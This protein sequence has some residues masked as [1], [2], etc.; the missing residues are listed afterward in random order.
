METS[1]EDEQFDLCE[2]PNEP[3]GGCGSTTLQTIVSTVASQLRQH[4]QQPTQL[5][6]PACA[7][8]MSWN[9]TSVRRSGDSNNELLLHLQFANGCSSLWFT[10]PI[11]PLS[12][13]PQAQQQFVGAD[14][15]HSARAAPHRPARA[16]SNWLTTTVAVVIHY[17]LVS[18][19]CTNSCWSHELHSRTTPRRDGCA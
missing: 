3:F 5:C 12:T 17:P 19:S 7:H 10:G 8:R 15:T 4:H 2:S 9:S 1:A 18:F 13:S 14:C 16:N 11:R 6:W